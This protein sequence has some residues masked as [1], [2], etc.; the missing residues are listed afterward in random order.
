MDEDLLNLKEKK[1]NLNYAYREQLKVLGTKYNEKY[2]KWELILIVLIFRK[3]HATDKK[4][5][6]QTELEHWKSIKE[7]LKKKQDE[8]KNYKHFLEKQI[9][10]KR[11]AKKQEEEINK[12]DNR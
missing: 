12:K 6:T 2:E 10:E 9:E 11:K 5:F 7:K 4:A 8:S 3:Q 1:N